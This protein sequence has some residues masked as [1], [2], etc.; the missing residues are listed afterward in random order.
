MKA[1]YV[2]EYGP[3]EAIRYGMLPDP[4]PGPGQVLVRTVAVAVDSVDTLADRS[5]SA[6]WLLRRCCRK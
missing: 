2:T 6:S 3:A 1:A 5:R 4:V